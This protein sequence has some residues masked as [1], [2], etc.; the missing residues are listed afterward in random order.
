M[1]LLEQPTAPGMTG[2]LAGQGLPP[3]DRG[4]DIGGVQFEPATDPTGSLS[5]NEGG[6]AA[7]EGIEHDLAATGTVPQRIGHQGDGLDRR[8]Q[9]E[10][11]AFGPGAAER[12]DPGVFQTLL[13]LRP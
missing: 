6:A 2:A 1:V 11:V 12:V 9:C 7:E 13:R 3:A 10:K 5:G 8:M 4:V